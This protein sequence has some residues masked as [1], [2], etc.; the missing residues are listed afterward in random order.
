MQ[1]EAVESTIILYYS[2]VISVLY[3]HWTISLPF[4][5]KQ[6]EG[7]IKVD[8]IPSSSRASVLLLLIPLLLCNIHTD[9]MYYCICGALY[10][11]WIEQGWK[12]TIYW[13]MDQQV[14]QTSTNQ[15]SIYQ[16]YAVPRDSIQIGFR[17]W[18]SE[19]DR[20][21]RLF[22]FDCIQYKYPTLIIQL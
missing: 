2:V 3:L 16:Y 6:G 18:T 7:H 1:D 13:S 20:T 11:F 4:W 9:I 19:L 17:S 5:K 21:Q 15:I 14:P 8:I 10:F 22:M 12:L